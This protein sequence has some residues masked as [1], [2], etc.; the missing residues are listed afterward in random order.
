MASRPNPDPGTRAIVGLS[1]AWLLLLLLLWWTPPLMLPYGRW[2]GHGG[3]AGEEDGRVE[4]K[5]RVE[6][7]GAGYY[8]RGRASAVVNIACDVCMAPCCFDGEPVA[9]RPAH[10]T[11]L[12]SDPRPLALK[13]RHSEQVGL[14]GWHSCQA[15]SSLG[16]RAE[17]R[18]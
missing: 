15:F 11:A 1:M 16:R 18:A 13:L 3:G 2:Q 10:H 12:L 5:L 4:A 6:P 17:M 7:V 9:F 8:L 14:P